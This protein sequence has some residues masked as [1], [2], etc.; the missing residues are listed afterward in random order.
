MQQ[1]LQALQ[2]FN[3]QTIRPL[4]H[5]A[6]CIQDFQ[7]FIFDHLPYSKVELK[8]FQNTVL[9][10]EAFASRLPLQWHFAGRPD[11]I[12][13]AFRLRY[14]YK[15]RYGPTGEEA[16]E[17]SSV[18]VGFQ[19]ANAPAMPTARGSWPAPA[20]PGPAGAAAVVPAPHVPLAPPPPLGGMGAA[21]LNALTGANLRDYSEAVVAALP[22]ASFRQLAP[23]A[24]A[25]LPPSY[26]RAMN[27]ASLLALDTTAL[28]MMDPRTLAVINENA[29]LGRR[30]ANA[31]E[32][33]DLNAAL[34]RRQL[35]LDPTYVGS[36]SEDFGNFDGWVRTWDEPNWLEA[37]DGP[38]LIEVDGPAREN[39]SVNLFPY[40]RVSL[41]NQPHLYRQ[42]IFWY[43]AGVP[44]QLTKAVRVRPEQHPQIG[45]F[46]GYQGPGPF[47]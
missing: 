4:R 16:D 40:G 29:F 33:A 22:A 35:A 42:L 12:H 14:T 27:M 3:D 1:F 5:N 6:P 25:T 44:H 8:D 23:G 20:G 10:D 17:Y 36:F 21:Q 39:D 37:F 46:V 24:I 43:F 19:L 32:A 34:I 13:R 26:F 2:G 9:F 18:L 11:P 30:P 7:A 45:L 31:R 47:P 38:V 41:F 15:T 28:G